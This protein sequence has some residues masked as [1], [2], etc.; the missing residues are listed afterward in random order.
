MANWG[1]GS[2]ICRKVFCVLLSF[3]VSLIVGPGI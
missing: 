3:Q 2:R 1:L